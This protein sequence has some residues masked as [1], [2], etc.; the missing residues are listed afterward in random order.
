MRWAENPD[1]VI[2]HV[3][4]A[5]HRCRKEFPEG[6]ESAG[7]VAR[8]VRDTPE[9]KIVVDEYRAHSLRR[10][11]GAV[12]E[13]TFPEG[14]NSRVRHGPRLTGAAACPH[15]CRRPPLRRPE[16]PQAIEDMFGIPIAE[17]R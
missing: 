3:P 4:K 9:P 10:D 7:Y 5:C 12:A 2:D 15:A 1:R 16:G 8:Q 14:V 13:E 6:A 17:G 11:C